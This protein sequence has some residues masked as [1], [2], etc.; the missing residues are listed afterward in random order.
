MT[1]VGLTKARKRILDP[2]IK[3]ESVCENQSSG[4]NLPNQ[5]TRWTLH[6]LMYGLDLDARR[7]SLGKSLGFQQ[8]PS[9]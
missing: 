5:A 4:A 1:I 6:V 9:A 8:K 7:P 2:P 3:R